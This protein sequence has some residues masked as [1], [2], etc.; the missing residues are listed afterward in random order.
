MDSSATEIALQTGGTPA[1]EQVPDFSFVESRIA[2]ML[3]RCLEHLL[4]RNAL[5]DVAAVILDVSRTSTAYAKH[6]G[7]IDSMECS[8][9]SEVSCWSG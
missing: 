5:D 9:T 8:A 7:Q 1:P 4:K 2:D 6:F 3:R